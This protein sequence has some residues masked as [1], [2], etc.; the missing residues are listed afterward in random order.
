[1][2]SFQ[3]ATIY[4]DHATLRGYEKCGLEKRENL[5]SALACEIFALTSELLGAPA[6]GSSVNRSN[7]ARG[8]EIAGDQKVMFNFCLRPGVQFQH[9]VKDVAFALGKVPLK[10]QIFPPGWRDRLHPEY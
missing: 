6:V 9:A 10:E 8:Q 5:T 4:K 1:M 7:R 3:I 2:A